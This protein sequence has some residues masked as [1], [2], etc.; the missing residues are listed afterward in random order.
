MLD[1][2]L[3]RNEPDRVREGIKKKGVDFDLDSFLALDGR[4]REL[5]QETEKLKHD[6]NVASQEISTLKKE[7][8]DAADAIER[9]QKT[10]KRIKEIDR[11]LKEMSAALDEQALAIPNIPHESVPY[12]TCPDHNV[13]IRRW[14]EI[15]EPPQKPQPHWEIGE[16]LGI[17][18]LAGGARLSGR[19]F[20]VLRGDGARLARA[21]V[22]FMLDIH[23][24]QGYEE[25]SVPYVVSRDCMIGTG[26]LPKLEEDMYSCEKDD[27]FLIP[28]AEVPVTNLHRNDILDGDDLPIKYTAF[29]PCFRREAGSYGQDTRGLI[30]VH[31]FDKVEMVKFVRPEDSYEELEKLLDDAVE[32]LQILKIPYRV[33]ELCSTDL[34]F[35]AAKCYDIE[36]YATGTGRWLEVSSCSNFE[37]FQARRANIRFKRDKADKPEFVHTLNGSGLALPRIIAT[38]LEI[39]QTPTGK[40]RIPEALVP[41]MGGT[42]F[43]EA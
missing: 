9:M 34:S 12:G 23:H 2:K 1:R 25:L 36:T 17:L 38:I 32:I 15:V 16:K 4:M 20:V 10:A 14:G 31:Q 35:S 33:I 28:T 43:L 11:E 21:L 30:R 26:Q 22:N 37:D 41:Y 19:G 13:E 42:E 18:D 27:L 8:G 6:R 29:S 7:K 40:V 24:R 3:I 5:I 39:N